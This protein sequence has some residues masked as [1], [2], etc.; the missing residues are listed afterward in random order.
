MEKAKRLCLILPSKIRGDF[1]LS[2]TF[3]YYNNLE[4]GVTVYSLGDKSSVQNYTGIS[5]V[6]IKKSKFLPKIRFNIRVI[7]RSYKKYDYY[8]I[9]S[10]ESFIPFFLLYSRRVFLEY[11]GDYLHFPTGQFSFF[12]DFTLRLLSKISLM[13]A[14]NIRFVSTYLFNTAEPYLRSDVNV[15]TYPPYVKEEFIE[16]F[17]PNMTNDS[18]DCV[19]I[20]NKEHSKGLDL[21]LP[22]FENRSNLKFKLHCVGV[23]GKSSQKVLYHGVKSRLDTLNII[24][25]SQVV[26]I[27]SREEGFSRVLI[28]A[29]MCSTPVITSNIP[30]FQELNDNYWPMCDF[31]LDFNLNQLS[32]LLL[33][34]NLNGLKEFYSSNF[35]LRSIQ[36]RHI[37]WL[38]KNDN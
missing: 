5:H 25:S 6:Q 22:A 1:T 17:E 9:S 34:Y 35:S 11:Q 4:I 19:F 26:L 30:V 16:S 14:Y 23:N 32:K 28:E 12:K 31:S 20:G 15:V 10:V 29:A 2:N 24:R 18:I 38:L 3:H 7:L 8:Q 33:D 27:P 13:L 21:I 36:I 37:N